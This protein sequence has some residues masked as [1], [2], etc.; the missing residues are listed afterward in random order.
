MS[1][2]TCIDC[3]A[4]FERE[5]TET[6]KR[7]CLDCWKLSKAGHKTDDPAA[8]AK[9]YRK[10]FEAGRATAMAESRDGG[11]TLDAERLRQLIRLCHPDLHNGSELATSVTSWLLD[12]R[13]RVA[14]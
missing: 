4:D 12:L 5:P 6:W 8:A 1:Y 10:G 7:R 2:A 14:A 3:G 13:K 11:A 9:W